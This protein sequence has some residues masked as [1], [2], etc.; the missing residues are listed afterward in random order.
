MHIHC[1]NLENPL[2]YQEEIKITFFSLN[3]ELMTGQCL[4][5]IFFPKDL[6]GVLSPLVPLCLAPD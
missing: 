5:C 6:L 2:K 4:G 3:P 1:R